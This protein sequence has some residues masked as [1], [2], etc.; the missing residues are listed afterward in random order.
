MLAGLLRCRAVEA[1]ARRLLDEGLARH[2]RGGTALAVRALSTLAGF[3]LSPRSVPTFE[4]A[5]DRDA[6]APVAWRALCS[7]D[8]ARGATT[9]PRLTRTLSAAPTRS[10]P[11]ED[12]VQAQLF[13]ALSPGRR[14]HLI[15]HVVWQLPL[16]ALGPALALLAQAGLGLAAA[17]L[18]RG[19]DVHDKYAVCQRAPGEPG[20]STLGR[21]R[22]RSY[23]ADAR[24]HRTLSEDRWLI[25]DH[26]A[27]VW[28][29]ARDVLTSLDA[30]LIA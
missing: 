12:I 10:P 28:T 20:E 4:E 24:S 16:D 13:G 3:G 27:N 9:L 23:D 21:L 1:P 17:N 30:V 18:G 19:A 11:I 8:A 5:L 2:A 7:F 25:V 29:H 14:V 6:T 15:D 26:A 22:T